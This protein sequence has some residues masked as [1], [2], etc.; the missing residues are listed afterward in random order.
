MIAFGGMVVYAVAWPVRDPFER[1]S[2]RVSYSVFVCVCTNAKRTGFKVPNFRALPL[3]LL[4]AFVLRAGQ[5]PVDCCF[6][7]F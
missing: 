4:G 5:N 3:K 7:L 1:R 6:V 2:V